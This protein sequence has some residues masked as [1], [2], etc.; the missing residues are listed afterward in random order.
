MMTKSLISNSVSYTLILLG[1]LSSAARVSPCIARQD[2]ISQ[3]SKNS[4]LLT[5]LRELKTVAEQ[6]SYQGTSDEFQVRDFLDQI[7]LASSFVSRVKLGATTEGR[8]LDAVVFAKEGGNPLPL[9]NADKRLVILIHGNIHSGECDG[10]EAILALM[11]DW[12]LDPVKLAQT[13]EKTVLVVLPNFNA[14]GNARVGKLHRPGQA[15]PDF[16][17][18]IRENPFGL[19]LNR[20]FMK[21]DSAEVRSLVRAIDAFDVDVLI[22]AH[23][24]NGSLHQY[25]LTYDLPHN[26]AANQTII[27]W[28]RKEF[29][30]TITMDLAKQNT[31]IFY[32]GNFS[33]DHK[34]WESYGHEPRY[35]TEYMGVRGKIG[36]LVESYS[37]ATYQRRVEASYQFIDACVS[38]LAKNSEKLANWLIP[39]PSRRESIPIQAKI[40][41]EPGTFLA[42][43]YSWK[44]PAK[45]NESRPPF[46]S[47]RD[48]DRLDQLNK[49]DYEVAL[50]NRGEGVLHVAAPTYYYIPFD[51]AW[52]ASRLRLHGVRMSEI[53]SS[54]A[55]KHSAQSISAT[56][57]RIQTVTKLTPYQM[58]TPQKFEVKEETLSWKMQPG[59]VVNT[60][61]PLA[62]LVAHLLEPHADDSLA[63]WNF[64]DPALQTNALYPVLRLNALPNG[65]V[66]KP[67]P[68]LS[69]NDHRPSDVKR[70]EL[71]IEKIYDPVSKVSFVGAV[72]Q[73][74]RWIPGKS[75]YIQQQQGRWFSVDCLTG[76]MTPWDLPSRMASSL[77][78]LNAFEEKD[79]A[80]FRN[81]ISAFDPTLEYAVVSQKNDLYLFQA[82][83]NTARQLTHDPDAAESV[84]TL[85]PD[86]KYVAFV[87]DNNIW[88]VNCES[89]E[90][91]QMTKDGA[92]EILNGY[93]DW[94]YQEEVYGR[95]N[96]KA[97]WWSPDGK[98]I[99]FLKLD[100]SPVPNFVINDSL[101]FEQKLENIRYPKAG[102]PNPFVSLHVLDVETGA[103][104]DV[105][106]P[107]YPAD[108]RL[109]V[110]VGWS[111]SQPSEMIYQVQNRI[112]SRLDVW[113]FDVLSKK[114]HRW[115]REESNAWIDVI[116]EPRFVNA[117]QFLWVSD[118][119][120]GRR[121]MF[122]VNRNGERKQLTKGEW[123][124]KDVAWMAADGSRIVFTA[125][126]SAPANTDLLV[127][128]TASGEIQSIETRPGVANASVHPSG[129]YLA[130]TWS[131]A[132]NPPEMWLRDRAG[133]KLRRLD[134]LQSDRFDYVKSS[135]PEQLT[136][137]TRDGFS[138]QTMIYKPTDFEV[139]KATKKYP[140]LIHVYAGPQAPTVQNSWVRRSDLWHRYL[141]EQGIVVM[142]CD[143]RSSLGRGNS[144]TWSIYKNLGAVELR[145][146]EDAVGWL[147]S[148]NWVDTD[149][150]GI[151][152][153]SYGGYFTAYAMTH[154]KL[155]RAGISGAPVTDWRNYDSIYTERYMSTPQ[156]NP[157]GYRTSS[158]VEA[159]K[160]LHG[161]LLLIHGEIDENV[162]MTNSLQFVHALQQANK[163]F[164]LMIYPSNRH[165]VTDPKQ[166]FHM[167]QMM[168]NFLKRE[169]VTP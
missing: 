132:E 150:L 104:D 76:A 157:E 137:T 91:R 31:P 128:D 165:G 96:F 27:S 156:L 151:W 145:D 3:D 11:R 115:T 155:F 122:F 124:V 57:Y 61:Q 93:L 164:D 162:H 110:R 46:P 51:A 43:G 114:N 140:V 52:A 97:Y 121:H 56:A 14:D 167:Y 58:H 28:M 152:G 20:D 105:P 125:H 106:L 80:R 134:S 153:W 163:S 35:S 16:G 131:N 139:G 130:H 65:T 49:V 87:R 127:L 101:S 9:S 82:Q 4:Q 103:I 94:V 23:T 25:D 30:P 129:E 148:Q 107:D 7:D 8:P 72:S 99:A 10:K 19:D 5:N 138:M 17:M 63:A 169:L 34:S 75:E 168:T 48:K 120:S 13:L 108:D 45:E 66:L 24:T 146:L 21:L 84:P 39:A 86:G 6:T 159:A 15:G 33:R 98:K 149:R 142:L 160:D 71:T 123:D 38:H 126:Q 68:T 2:N 53:S 54:E 89:T 109:V 100:E 55:Q 47:P 37:Y 50:V 141:A 166:Q 1:L 102:Q 144:D 85:S 147:K 112:Q 42:K 117:D 18:G 135:P 67:L 136:V 40:V 59:W 12:L 161:R 90:V 60:D 77:L 95:G 26:P 116:D 79:V 81:S 154:S 62:V 70:E 74:P 158:V 69:I 44:D 78:K 64:F 22:D 32:Y 111:N 36:I 83:G 113:S 133:N 41:T 92:P 119:D 73:L 118:A 88:V 29:F 143:N